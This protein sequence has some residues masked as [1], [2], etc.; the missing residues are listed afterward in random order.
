MTYDPR[1]GD[2]VYKHAAC[3]AWHAKY[4]RMAAR[5]IITTLREFLE[6]SELVQGHTYLEENCKSLGV[7][8]PRHAGCV[9]IESGLVLKDREQP[10]WTSAHT[11]ARIHTRILYLCTHTHLLIHT[12]YPFLYFTI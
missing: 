6:R 8:E 4:S 11:R 5:S 3:S 1:K 7:W 10:L 12:R 9:R 2:N